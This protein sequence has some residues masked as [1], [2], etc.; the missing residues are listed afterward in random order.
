MSMTS[1]RMKFPTE[2]RRTFAQQCNQRRVV[3]EIALPSCENEICA[4]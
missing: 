4:A 3:E 1:R 2:I